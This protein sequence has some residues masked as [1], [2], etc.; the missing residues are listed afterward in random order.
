MYPKKKKLIS[1]F[2][3][4]N[5]LPHLS[6]NLKKQELE[7]KRLR[8]FGLKELREIRALGS[9]GFMAVSGEGEEPAD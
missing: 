4:Q 6:E 8:N 9:R 1:F 5:L 3:R 7:Q 2:I